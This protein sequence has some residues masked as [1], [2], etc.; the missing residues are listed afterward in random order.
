MKLQIYMYVLLPSETYLFKQLLKTAVRYLKASTSWICAFTA[1]ER[2][3]LKKE[4][5]H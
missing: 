2:H 1:N 5:Q 4:L 3:N